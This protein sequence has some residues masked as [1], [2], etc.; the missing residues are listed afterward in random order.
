[1]SV[2]TCAPTERAC[3]RL[4]NL[5]PEKI[6]CGVSS[7]VAV[8]LEF[9]LAVTA[10]SMPI[11]TLGIYGRGGRTSRVEHLPDDYLHGENVDADQIGR[12]CAGVV[13]RAK[14]GVVWR[15][16]AG[17]ID[18]PATQRSEADQNSLQPLA[19]K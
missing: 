4:K 15:R 3:L 11:G 17:R 10:A 2:S 12:H 19:R 8:L 13:A 1:M 9:V 14:P 6:G 7:R 5:G 16:L 18:L